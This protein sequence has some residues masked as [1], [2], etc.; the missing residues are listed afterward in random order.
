MIGDVI[1]IGRRLV[2]AKKLCD[3]RQARLRRTKAQAR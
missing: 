1:E 3:H 2:D